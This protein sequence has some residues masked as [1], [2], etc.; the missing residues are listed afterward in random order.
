MLVVKAKHEQQVRQ[1]VADKDAL[2]SENAQLRQELEELRRDRAAFA[3]DRQREE[4]LNTL[5]VYQNEHIKGGLSDI[6]THLAHAVAR[7]KQTLHKV[8]DASA[9]F[10]QVAA[11]TARITALLGTVATVAQNCNE[12]VAHLSDHAARINDVL[13]LIR[14]VAEQTNLLALNAAI[15]AARAGESGR[16][17]AVVAGE[18]RMLADKTQTAI[19]DIRDV[20]HN[21]L[22]QIA[23]VKDTAQ[24]LVSGVREA[25]R[26]VAGFQRQLA[27]LHTD[28]N[29]AFDEVRDTADGV[30]VS[31]AKLDHII[32]KVN[33]YLSIVKRAPAFEFVDH[34][35]CRLGQ[36]Y[37]HGD[38]KTFFARSRHYRELEEP[39]ARV[40]NGTRRVFA[41]LDRL[42]LDYAALL[43]ALD[44][45]ECN[46]DKVF[47]LLDRI[48]ADHAAP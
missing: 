25:D 4:Q 31:L 10:D 3:N 46:S 26:S 14:T 27:G 41:L 21:M 11:E 6:Q 15:E 35:H 20:I 5:M 2:I 33:T 36:W 34:H 32:W 28:V 18:V 43:D 24:D 22:T 40:H 16:G 44:E 37:E 12:V 30:F 19:A 1:L 47:T 45:M 42:P 48:N 39:H 17:F 38:G 9:T 8:Q 29:G 23:S 13:S 7:A